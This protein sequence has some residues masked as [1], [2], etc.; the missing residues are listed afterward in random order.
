MEMS[1][2]SRPSRPVKVVSA[3][4]LAVA[5]QSCFALGGL[6]TATST[7]N[8]IKTGLYAFV[9]VLSLIYLLWMGVMA[10]SEKKSWADFGWGLVYVS[11]VGGSV[12]IGS[13]AFSLFA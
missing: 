4:F 11:L 8:T 1:I 2:Y 10:F 9:G 6:D 13:W 7:A 12:A 5:A 3:L